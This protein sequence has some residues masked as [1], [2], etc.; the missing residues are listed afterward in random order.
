MLDLA[1]DNLF[2]EGK[3]FYNSAFGR[4]IRLSIRNSLE[5]EERPADSGNLGAKM[6]ELDSWKEARGVYG[7]SQVLGISFK[8]G[9]DSVLRRVCEIEEELGSSLPWCV[10]GDFNMVLHEGEKLGGP[11]NLPS[12]EVFRNFVHEPGLVDLPLEGSAFC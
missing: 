10:C 11:V 7:M 4:T 1:R 3:S 9:E 8:G 12:L 5:E 6:K 2:L